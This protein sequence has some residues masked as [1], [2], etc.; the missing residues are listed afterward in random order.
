MIVTCPAPCPMRIL[1][2]LL[3]WSDPF[4]SSPDNEGVTFTIADGPNNHHQKMTVLE[5]LPYPFTL[6]IINYKGS[7]APTISRFYAGDRNVLLPTFTRTSDDRWLLQ[8]GGRLDYEQIAPDISFELTVPENENDSIKPRISLT[9]LNIWDNEPR[10]DSTSGICVI[11]ELKE[12][13]LTDC[14]YTL[15][16]ADGMAGNTHTF[17]IEGQNAEEDIFEFVA[18][19]TT[20][21]YTK[22]YRLQTKKMLLFEERELYSFTVYVKDAG[23]MEGNARVIVEVEDLPNLPPKWT[24]SFVSDRFDEKTSR[25]YQV[26]AIDGDTKIN[27]PVNYTIRFDDA[28]QPCEY[29][30]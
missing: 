21:L 24:K 6:A 7:T 9:L 19:V 10:L 1:L 27:K 12:P 30:K 17:R 26:M 14:L 8:V 11:D 4:F 15:Y 13:H 29:I 20:G 23:D 28:E 2:P 3:D 22:E 18:G 16:D 25:S 5:E